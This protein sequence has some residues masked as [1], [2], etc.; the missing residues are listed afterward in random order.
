MPRNFSKCAE[1]WGFGG[2]VDLKVFDQLKSSEFES[3]RV[4]LLKLM[5]DSWLQFRFGCTG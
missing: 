1:S 4:V 3:N 5:D 2:Y